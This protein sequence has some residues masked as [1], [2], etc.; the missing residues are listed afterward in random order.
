MSSVLKFGNSKS[1]IDYFP[2]S[3]LKLTLSLHIFEQA[4]LC[5]I[6]GISLQT[7]WRGLK[8]HSH[9]DSLF[10]HFQTANGEN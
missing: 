4:R 6:D 8:Y 1:N 9:Y 3:W 2:L 10:D 7:M 5:V